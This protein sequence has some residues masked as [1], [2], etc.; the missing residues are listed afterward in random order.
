M[1]N[2]I[3][4]IDFTS[5]MFETL[6]TATN[7][8]VPYTMDTFK[9]L[10]RKGIK[11][12]LFL[13]LPDAAKQKS[14]LNCPV[15]NCN[16]VVFDGTCVGP[17]TEKIEERHRYEPKLISDN[18]MVRVVGSRLTRQIVA[19]PMARQYLDK[20]SGMERTVGKV[21]GKVLRL[22]E[23]EM[24]FHLLRSGSALEKAFSAYLSELVIVDGDHVAIP[25]YC[26]TMVNDIALNYC[27]VNGF[28]QL[29]NVQSRSLFQCV[30]L[31]NPQDESVLKEF[32]NIM[33]LLGNVLKHTP[34]EHVSTLH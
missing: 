25:E 30:C 31:T 1:S 3:L 18:R 27:S 12:F 26:Q 28:I 4:N 5:I 2:L 34:S 8:S 33:P 16:A 9:K 23:N 13:T 7:L 17:R 11:G 10:I 22:D 20:L 14:L 29:P 21:P 24:L 6:Q 15:P 19:N 32:C